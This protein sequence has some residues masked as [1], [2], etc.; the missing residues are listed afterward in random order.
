VALVEL[1]LTQRSI[2]D[3]VEWIAADLGLSPRTTTTEA[4]SLPVAASRGRHPAHSFVSNSSRHDRSLTSTHTI[5]HSGSA[6]DRPTA[7]D[8]RYPTRSVSSRVIGI[9]NTGSNC[10]SSSV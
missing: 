1:R 3:V 8:R 5:V 2:D 10:A 4:R 9:P 7:K 6:A